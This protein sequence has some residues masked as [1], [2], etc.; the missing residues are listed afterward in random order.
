MSKRT[1]LSTLIAVLM[2]LLKH[3]ATYRFLAVVLVAVGAA[4]G[5]QIAL[6]IQ[7][8]ACAYLG[9]IG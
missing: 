9:C 1:S 6:A 4:Q 3:K 8:L 2:A 5:E 7:T